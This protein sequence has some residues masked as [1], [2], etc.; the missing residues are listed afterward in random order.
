MN[1]QDSRP[2]RSRAPFK[3]KDGRP[4]GKS[5]RLGHMCFSGG[6]GS[7]KVLTDCFFTTPIIERAHQVGQI[8]A[9]RPRPIV[10]KF[11]NYKDCEK[12]SESGQEI[13][14]ATLRGS[15]S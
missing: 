9:N 15:V 7:P 8:N 11:L 3:S 1:Q 13:K 14:R 12:N 4:T 5:G 6:I 10:M 2:G